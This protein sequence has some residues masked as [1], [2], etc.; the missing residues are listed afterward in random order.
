[1]AYVSIWL[2]RAASRWP[3]KLALSTPTESVTYRQLDERVDRTA[4]ALASIGLTPQSRV[5]DWHHNGVDSVCAMIAFARAGIVRVPVS[6]QS[7]AVEV[8]RVV[9]HAGADAVLCGADVAAQALA[10][11]EIADDKIDLLTHRTDGGLPPDFVCLDQVDLLPEVE[12][13]GLAWSDVSS[14]RYTSGT[15][16]AP[17]AVVL[18]EQAEILSMQV[19]SAESCRM[20]SDDRFLH[21]QPFS[22]GGGAYVPPMILAGASGWVLGKFDATAALQWIDEHKITVVKLVPTMLIRMLESPVIDSVDLSSLRLIMYG[23]SGMP[24]PALRRAMARFGPIL[25]Q[26]YG[27]T[28]VPSAISYL[29]PEDHVSPRPDGRASKL[30]SAGKPFSTIEVRIMNDE[31]DWLSDGQEGEIAVRSPH[32]MSEYLH[33]PERTD[34]VLRGEWVM[35][36]DLGRLDSEGYIW[37]V[38]RRNDVIISGGMNV[39]PVEVEEVLY[40]HDDVVE[41]VVYGMEHAEWIETVAAA[42]VL[43]DG[44]VSSEELLAYCRDRLAGYKRPK[45]LDIVSDLPKNKYGKFDRLAVREMAVAR[46]A[47]TAQ[48]SAE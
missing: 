5:I 18:T 23:A 38:G 10:V 28:E 37:I 40:S 35:T 15:T 30:G 13:P 21:L 8:A 41:A 14:I 47:S 22:H 19:I 39:N 3:D 42:V 29:S 25:C 2:Q 6:P 20:T 48:T 27:Q 43:R 31:G 34:T 36:G 9:T 7:T 16:G 33:D 1:M 44:L 17:K 26:S 32:R 4:R 46:L 45:V 24:E 12:L 11:A